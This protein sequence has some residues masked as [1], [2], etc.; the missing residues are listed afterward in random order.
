MLS[1]LITYLNPSGSHFGVSDD[2]NIIW[3]DF[4]VID[5]LGN[6][7]SFHVK[8]GMDS[9]GFGYHSI[10]HIRVGTEQI[11]TTLIEARWD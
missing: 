11:S 9:Q 7:P 1:Y 3:S 10:L 2:P 8:G 6:F 4:E 5:S